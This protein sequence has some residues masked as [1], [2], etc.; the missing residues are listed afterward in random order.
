M[1]QKVYTKM[2]MKVL[3]AA[4][5]LFITVFLIGLIQ[6]SEQEKVVKM[7]RRAEAERL[8]QEKKDLQNA[9]L[10][11][12]A[13]YDVA[14]PL[15]SVD[16]RGAIVSGVVASVEKREKIISEIRD[17]RGLS[18]EVGNDNLK[19]P[20]FISGSKYGDVFTLTGKVSSFELLSQRIV[21]GYSLPVIRDESLI[22][23]P[24]FI[25]SPVVDSL[26]FQEWLSSYLS[27]R[28]NRSFILEGGTITLAGEATAE[29]E[30]AWVSAL[31][32]LRV[33]VESELNVYPSEMIFPSYDYKDSVVLSERELSLL[34]DELSMSGVLFEQGSSKADSSQFFKM[35]IIATI[36]KATSK[37]VS[38]GLGMQAELTGDTGASKSLNTKRINNV[39]EGLKA[40]GVD[41]SRI[42]VGS[43]N[44]PRQ[45][46]YGVTPITHRV[47]VFVK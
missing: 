39:L 47:Q 4:L 37:S 42:E 6:K 3:V 36:I 27:F 9:V 20:G 8:I 18:L 28:G 13:E 2:V 25:D 1:A 45:N 30:R 12:M 46:S 26:M 43:I 22:E 14:E 38:F 7:K 17:Q 21:S 5:G 33:N 40:R 11:Q 31:R 19:V 24:Y 15:F 29:Q 44:K 41:I 34:K 32:R 23:A 10:E 35:D 16:E